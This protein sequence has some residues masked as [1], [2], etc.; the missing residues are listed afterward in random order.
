MHHECIVRIAIVPLISHHLSNSS[1]VS[2]PP[3]SAHAEKVAMNNEPHADASQ[4]PSE[5]ASEYCTYYPAA[6]NV[7]IPTSM[8]PVF[9]LTTATVGSLLHL[10]TI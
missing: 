1:S 10:V 7:F 8:F 5:S 4:Q 6:Y 3:A 9:L 2:T